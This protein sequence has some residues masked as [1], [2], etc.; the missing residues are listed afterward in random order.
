ML[1]PVTDLGKWKATHSRPV[2]I[3]ALR[4]N[5]AVEKIARANLNAWL[6]LTFIWPR[7]LVRTVFE[8]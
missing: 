6:T 1:A 8:V 5:E 7:V 4:W 2:V 3:D